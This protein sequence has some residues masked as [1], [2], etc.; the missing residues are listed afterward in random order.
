MELKQELQKSLEHLKNEFAKLQVGRANPA[1]IEWITVDA[2]GSIQP[3][4]SL[5]NVGTLDAMSEDALK[6]GKEDIQKTIDETIKTIDE[7]TKTKEAD[8]MKI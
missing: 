2:Y 5:A 1:I 8:I 3:L 4:K 7:L 6:S